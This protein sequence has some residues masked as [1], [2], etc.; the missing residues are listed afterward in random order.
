MK[1]GCLIIATILCI[2]TFI[3]GFSQAD[4]T[5]TSVF[6]QSLKNAI[7][8][9]YNAIGENAHLYNGSEYVSFNY[10]SDKNPF[11]ESISLMNGSIMYDNVLYPNVPL[12]YDIQ[13]DEVIINKYDENYRIKLINDKI[14][15]F[16]LDGHT[17][18]RIVEDSTTSALPETGY[19]DLLYNG[20]VSVF[21]KRKKKYEESITNTG[22]VTQFI[23]DDH[24]FIKKNNVYYAVGNKK[25]TLKVF[26]DKKKDIQKLLRK[27][28]IKF[29]PN[30]EHGIVK[31][32]QY[33]DQLKN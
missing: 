25:S 20:K 6:Q 32:A 22:A 24:Y 12:A 27:N 1:T 5:D 3:P 31:A 23:E 15:F 21:A 16:S 17:F 13:K 33:Y 11:F 19:Y 4:Q 26:K 9:Y 2:L 7:S 30:P 10:Q 28:K 29:S 18:V 14:E 8:A